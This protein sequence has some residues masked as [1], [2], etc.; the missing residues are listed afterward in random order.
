MFAAGS[1]PDQD[2]EARDVVDLVPQLPVFASRA[3]GKI[4]RSFIVM[5]AQAGTGQLATEAIIKCSRRIDRSRQP[6]RE[7]C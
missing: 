4:Q 6:V 7:P 1:I 3:S 5:T 2:V